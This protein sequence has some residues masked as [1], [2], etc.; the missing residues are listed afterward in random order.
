MY[1]GIREVIKLTTWKRIPRRRNSPKV[2]LLHTR[3]LDPRGDES[4]TLGVNVSPG[5]WM[6]LALQNG[7]KTARAEPF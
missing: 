3:K 5:K 7:K 6:S 2:R 1:E 4:V